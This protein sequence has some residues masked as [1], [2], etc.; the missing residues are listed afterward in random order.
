MFLRIMRNLLKNSGEFHQFNI[1]RNV[2]KNS[3]E[4]QEDWGKLSKIFRRTFGIKFSLILILICWYNKNQ[5]IQ[6]NLLLWTADII[7]KF[8]Y[9]FLKRTLSELNF[10]CEAT[11]KKNNQ[12]L[13]RNISKTF[14]MFSESLRND[15]NLKQ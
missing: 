7:R 8:I 10:T 1:R 11:K 9:R 13:L 15:S 14:S 3:R 12:V 4:R 5:L 2:I 6:K